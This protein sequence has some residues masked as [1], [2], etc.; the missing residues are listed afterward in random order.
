MTRKDRNAER[1]L[2]LGRVSRST[3]GGVRGTIEAFGL[4]TPAVRIS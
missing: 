2:T 4:Y 1:R 3:K